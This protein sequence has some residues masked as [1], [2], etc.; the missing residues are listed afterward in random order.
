MEQCS[1]SAYFLYLK[2]DGKDCDSSSKIYLFILERDKKRASQGGRA[3]EKE[4][5]ADSMLSTEPDTGLD[6]RTLR[7]QAET[8]SQTLK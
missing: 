5:Q 2:L 8:N 3:G 7:S 6:P 4:S 1:L